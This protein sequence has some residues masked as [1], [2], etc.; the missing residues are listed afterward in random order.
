[1]ARIRGAEALISIT[2]ANPLVG[3]QTALG[4]SFKWVRNFNME[5]RGD[6]SET[7]H[8]GRTVDTLDYQ[9]HGW[10]GSFQVDEEDSAAIAYMLTMAGYD[11]A[12]QGP[13]NVVV[14][15]QFKY[16]VTPIGSRLI[17]FDTIMRSTGVG[18]Q[19]RKDFI[20]HNFEFKA[21]SAEIVP[22]FGL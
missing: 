22:A 13:P 2:S 9:H 14:M 12:R 3:I 1:M 7:E 11:R 16:R 20:G 17:L 6:I 5:E 15:V 4:G 18:I 10:S 21:E 8:V 19:G